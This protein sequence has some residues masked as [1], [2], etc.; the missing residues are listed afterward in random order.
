[1]QGEGLG[2]ELALA[3]QGG[4][5]AHETRACAIRAG[6]RGTHQSQ[7]PLQTLLLVVAAAAALARRAVLRLGC[8]G[9]RPAAGVLV[10][11]PPREGG[12]LARC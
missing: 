11:R 2:V 10:Q 1:M 7:V 5:P 12:E 8:L 6:P 9:S 3:S 4:T